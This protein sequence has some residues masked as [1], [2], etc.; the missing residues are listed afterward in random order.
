[1][2]RLPHLAAGVAILAAGLALLAAAVLSTA[3]GAVATTVQQL[4]AADGMTVVDRLPKS[5]P[6]IEAFTWPAGAPV[7]RPEEAQARAAFTWLLQ[8]QNGAVYTD[9]SMADATH[10]FASAELGQ[11]YRT[12][13]GGVTWPPVLNLGFPRYWYGVHAQTP[14]S[15]FITGFQNQ[16]G[17]GIARWSTNGGGSWTNDI[18]IDPSHWLTINQFA[19]PL[20][21]VATAIGSGL[22]YVTTNGGATALDWTQVLADPTQGWFA[23]NLTFMASNL[24]VYV[25]GISF[26]QSTNGGL[27]YTRRASIDPVFD[28]GVSFPDVLHGWTGGGQ[29][30]QPVQGWVHR[31]TDGGQDWSGRILNPSYPI[32]SLHFLDESLGFAVGGNYFQGVGGIWSTTDGGTSWNLDVDTGCEMKGIDAKRVGPDSMAVW[33]AGSRSGVGRIYRTTFHY[34]PAVGGTG[35]PAPG[36]KAILRLQAAPNPFGSGTVVRL[37]T[38]GAGA[39]S[40]EIVD[41]AGRRIRRLGLEGAAPAGRDALWDGRDHLGLPVA[42]GIYYA[43]HRTPSGVE[44]LPLVLVR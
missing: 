26:C 4:V 29:I 31:T 27:T 30:S 9:L 20:H 18:V 43:V 25:T 19:D 15:V 16:T 36:A 38:R 42:S 32:R 12:T 44:S 24:H 7:A 33:C 5:G 17:E 2:P 41:A 14:D 37:R 35:D 10:G 28:G 21:G 22:T 23:G 34:P 6:G 39:M 40:L 1:M 11:V 8:S 13:N 3:A